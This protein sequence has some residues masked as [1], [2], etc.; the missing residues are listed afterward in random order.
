MLKHLLNGKFGA[1]SKRSV[2]A[3]ENIIASFI[4]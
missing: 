3:V 1:L 4:F 2:N